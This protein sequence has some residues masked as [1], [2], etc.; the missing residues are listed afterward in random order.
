VKAT[1]RWLGSPAPAPIPFSGK[2][3]PTN[4]TGKYACPEGIYSSNTLHSFSGTTGETMS[5]QIFPLRLKEPS[6]EA[7]F[8]GGGAGL[9]IAMGLPRLVTI[10]GLPVRF[11]FSIT[12]KHVALNFDMGIM[13]M[14]AMG[15]S[16]SYGAQYR[17]IVPWSTPMVNKAGARTKPL[18]ANIRFLAGNRWD[19]IAKKRVTQQA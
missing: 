19:A 18:L 3:V 15:T 17:R 11:T 10:T 6:Q 12:A 14:D 13:S 8:S 1:I 7:F 16:Y 5:P 4:S 2:W 9:I